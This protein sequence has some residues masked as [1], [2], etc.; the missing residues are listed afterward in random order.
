ML[1]CLYTEKL[2]KLLQ[3][4]LSLFKQIIALGPLGTGYMSIRQS[5]GHVII[6]PQAALIT[7][8]GHYIFG[9][10]TLTIRCLLRRGFR[11]C[12]LVSC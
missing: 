9:Q 2:L 7:E 6:A 3:Q 12:W 5:R 4:T 8:P 10:D 11:V 1:I